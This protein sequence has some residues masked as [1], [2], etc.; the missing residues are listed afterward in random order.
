MKIAILGFG[1]EG[2]CAFEYFSR[3]HPE[4]EIEVFDQARVESNVVKITTIRDFVGMDFS[5]F[6]LVIRSPSI[7]PDR[8]KAR[9]L[10]SMTAQFFQKCPA[11]IIG[12]TGTKGKGTTCSLI[13]SILERAGKKVWLVGNIGVP[14][15]EVLDE[16][17]DNDIVVYEL[18]SFQLWDLKK[19]P[20]VAVVVHIELDHQDVHKSFDEYLAAKSNIAL[21]QDRNGK[22]VFDSSNDHAVAIAAQSVARK[23]PYPNRDLAHVENGAFYYGLKELCPTSVLNI[24]G[25]HNVMNALAAISAV[26]DWTL[27]EVAIRDGLHDFTGLPHRLKFVDEVDGVGYYDDSISTTAGS[28]IAAIKSFDRPEIL[29]LGGSPKGADFG[30]LAQTVKDYRVKWVVLIG[31]EAVR[32]EQAL[33]AVHYRKITNLGTAKTMREIVLETKKRAERGD[34]VLLSPACASFGMF[35]NYADRGDQFIQAVQGLSS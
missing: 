32:L 35:K 27:D 16:I 31:E 29:I 18:S 9:N 12:V 13:K 14:A 21:W 10:S 4:A 25:A 15:L 23:A 26:A 22:I 20:Q 33:N 30:E 19:S 34:V 2:R 11:K 3:R 7:R 17:A 24:L 5:D 1:V 8:I 6:D 28:T